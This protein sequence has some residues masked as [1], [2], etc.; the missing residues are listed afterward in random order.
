V[1]AWAT[2]PIE[3]CPDAKLGDLERRHEHPGALVTAALMF[4]FGV[5]FGALLNALW[6]VSWDNFLISRERDEDD[7]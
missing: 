4:L 7:P 6:K 2:W 5:A 1:A 3:R